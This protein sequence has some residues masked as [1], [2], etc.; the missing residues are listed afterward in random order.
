MEK[1]IKSFN[2]YTRNFD[3]NNP[4]IR[5]KVVHTFKVLELS[6]YLATKLG[7]NNQEVYLSKLIAL[8]HDIGRFKQYEKY[9]TFVDYQS[10]DHAK[11]AIDL[12]F[13]Q[14]LI[15][16]YTEDIEQ[17]KIIYDA[18]INHNRY[19]ID[20]NIDEKSLKFVHLIRDADKL[21]NYR[22]KEYESFEVLLNRTKEELE[23]E[24]IST[25]VKEAIMNRKLVLSNTRKTKLD[26][27]MSWMAFVFDLYYKES[28]I[29]IRDNDLITRCA[30]RLKPLDASYDL[31]I[32]VMKDYVI[33]RIDG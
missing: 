11:M 3:L 26:F 5:L 32:D 33:G 14:G 12:L 25:S 23:K 30:K 20:T 16:D 6:E 7:F 24:E 1:A 4:N 13:K 31:L 27:Y 10:E 8:L 2:D 9:Q 19:M 21:D 15:S 18:I 22:V 17:Q 29:Y 28:L